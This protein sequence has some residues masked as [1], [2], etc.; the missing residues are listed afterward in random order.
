M[1]TPA[2]ANATSGTP[3][4]T[5]GVWWAPTGTAVPTDAVTALNVAFIGL[6][7]VTNDGLVGSE[8][9][10]TKDILDWAGITV[11]TLITGFKD[12]FKFGFL[13]FLNDAVHTAI[14]GTGNVTVTAANGT[15]GKQL[16][17]SH[18]GAAFP[19]GVWVFELGVAAGTRVRIV[20]VDGQVTELDDTNYKSDDLVGQKVTLTAF[21]DSTGN[22]HYTYTDDGKKTS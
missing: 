8:K 10:D 6:G 21:A 19:H 7:Y 3:L 14:R 18:N 15:H 5:G 4:V 13:E 17:I 1:G 22:T 2:A 11:A 20:V 16:K 9:R 12:I